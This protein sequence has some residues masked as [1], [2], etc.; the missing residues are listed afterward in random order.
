MGG[1]A[2][3]PT[4][5]SFYTGPQGR[6]PDPGRSSLDG[7]DAQ[8]AE[9]DRRPLGLQADLA[10]PH[11]APAGAVLQFPV[12]VQAQLAPVERDLV[13]VP[14][15]QRLLVARQELRRSAPVGAQGIHLH[16]DVVDVPDVARVAV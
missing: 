4:E 1:G 2:S 12:D 6:V 3:A 9:L 10:R 16:R 14:F 11:L 15:A 13:A 5:G 8:V 7:R